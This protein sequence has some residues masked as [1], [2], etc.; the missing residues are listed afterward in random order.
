MADTFRVRNQ[1]AWGGS[2]ASEP[3]GSIWAP[4]APL[5]PSALSRTSLF[6][7]CRCPEPHTCAA[8]AA[9]GDPAQSWL[10]AARPP[11]RLSG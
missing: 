4:Y 10:E 11:K 3:E 1:S 2:A 8:S 7:P 6:L 5:H 9:W